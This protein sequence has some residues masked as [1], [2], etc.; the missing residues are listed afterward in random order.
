MQGPHGH[1]T[2]R[3]DGARARCGGPAMCPRCAAELRQ[4]Q[5]VPPPPALETLETLDAAIAAA[6]E[7]LRIAEASFA[8]YAAE[9]STHCLAGILGLAIAMATVIQEE[10]T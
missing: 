4:S 2:T 10:A 8:G 5:P 6:R 3:P 1:V 7:H 9:A